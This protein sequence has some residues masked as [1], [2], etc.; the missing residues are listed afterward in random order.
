MEGGYGKKGKKKEEGGK[1][2]GRGVLGFLHP[3]FFKMGVSKE[4]P[5]GHVA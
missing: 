3:F 1:V 2:K 4:N 5:L